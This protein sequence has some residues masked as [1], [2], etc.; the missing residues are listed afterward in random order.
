ML[1]ISFSLFLWF[2]IFLL[3]VLLIF[4]FA[5]L[6][7]FQVPGGRLAEFAGS[8]RVFGWTM[9]G[10]RGHRD[11]GDHVHS[12]RLVEILKMNLDQD[13]YQ[14]HWILG[15]VVPLAMFYSCLLI[16]VALLAAATPLIAQH[17]EVW[18]VIAVRLVQVIIL[19]F[20]CQKGVGP[21]LLKSSNIFYLMNI[22]KT[23]SFHQFLSSM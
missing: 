5:S 17:V 15:A 6:S 1:F 8:K 14:N 22:L 4:H 19:F 23:I 3:F 16:Q 12:W 7:A 13:L 18:M 9:G 21:V 2:S 20:S 11:D 10:V